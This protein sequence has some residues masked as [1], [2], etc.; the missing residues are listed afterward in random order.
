MMTKY[1]C[2]P[3][4]AP[5]PSKC[6]VGTDASIGRRTACTPLAAASNL[7]INPA[8]CVC[9]LRTRQED[10]FDNKLGTAIV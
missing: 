3:D 1:S 10:V 6:G 7:T 8:G 4:G 5:A 9:S 2:H